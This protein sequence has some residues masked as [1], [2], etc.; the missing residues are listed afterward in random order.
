MNM[1]TTGWLSGLIGLALCACGS[2]AEPRVQP[3]APAVN[4]EDGGSPPVPTAPIDAAPS[5]TDASSAT[6][7]DAGIVSSHRPPIDAGPPSY[8]QCPSGTRHAGQANAPPDGAQ[9]WCERAKAG[10]LV[11]VTTLYADGQ[12]RSK[13]Q[14][15]GNRRNG[16]TLH[17]YPDGRLWFRGAVKTDAITLPTGPQTYYYPNGK[18]AEQHTYNGKGVPVG[19]SRRW[20]PNGALEVEVRRGKVR[21][22]RILA[23]NRV[24]LSTDPRH[25]PFIESSVDDVIPPVDY[26]V[27]DGQVY[28][29]AH[30]GLPTPPARSRRTERA[31]EAAGAAADASS[32]GHGDG[33]AGASF[34]PHYSRLPHL[35][36]RIGA[37]SASGSRR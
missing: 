3:L 4:L 20:Y 2:P 29:D 5:P 25:D 32:V 1:Q 17:W 19:T 15:R 36:D 8:S 12:L 35:P 10:G 7:A 28:A 21:R 14:Y 9:A 24:V 33:V 23:P 31:T 16:L 22:V 13:A 30:A 11:E 27:V 6:L 34:G 26:S 37:S 18:K